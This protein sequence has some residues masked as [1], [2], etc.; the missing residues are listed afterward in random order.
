MSARDK[1]V[2]LLDRLTV[3]SGEGKIGWE[4]AGDDGPYSYRFRAGSGHTVVIDSRDDDGRPPIDLLVIGP[5]GDVVSELLS[6]GSGARPDY[7][8]TQLWEQAK[9]FAAGTSKVL[10]QL[11]RELPLSNDD[12]PF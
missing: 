10:D 6:T 2:T 3:L 11:L 8:L 7:Q 9:D 4:P 12:I 5:H 1:M